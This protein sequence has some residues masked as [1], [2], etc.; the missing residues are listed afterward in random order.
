[1]MTKLYQK[2]GDER[3]AAVIELALVAPVLALMTVGVVD[4]SNAF[5]R[6]LQLEQ[7]AQRSIEKIMQTTG[8]LTVEETIKQEAVCQVN[9]TNANGSCKTGLLTA[10]DVTVTYRL[11]CDAVQVTP[12][13]SKCTAGQ[14]E[15]RYISVTVAS[16]Y[17][18]MFP[19]H[20]KG[21]GTDGK[22]KVEAVA[23][24]RIASS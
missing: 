1:M 2:L 10:A 9:G 14:K 16:S 15:A 12:Y 19:L 5:S 21:I 20:F 13:T 8:N 11:E 18:P 4:M 6:K 22:Y 7:A 17:T 23:G 3:G 24:M